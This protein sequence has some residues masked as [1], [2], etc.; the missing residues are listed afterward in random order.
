MSPK[1]IIVD[2]ERC[3]NCS[4]CVIACKDEFVGN[5]HAPWSAPQK[6]VGQFWIDVRALER[7]S[8]PRLKM[9]FLPVSCQHCESPACRTACPTGAI[10]Q[11]NDGLTWIDSTL[12]DGCGLCVKA[13]PYDAI[14][15]DEERGLAQKCTGCAHLVDEGALPRCVEACPHDVF[16]FVDATAPD[17]RSDPAIS[18]VEVLHPEFGTQPRV[19]WRNLPL[20]RLA[21]AVVERQEDEVVAGAR[22]TVSGQG[23]AEARQTTTDA[24]GQFALERLPPGIELDVLI[25]KA[26]YLPWTTRMTT[27]TDHDLGDVAL[28]RAG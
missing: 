21:G 14:F 11:R 4:L 10:K 26:G 13:C 16:D 1:T 24:F 5:D 18:T 17:L 23:L 25:E 8:A 12:C 20:P 15:L 9:S 28:D 7:G 22:V 6:E 3:S 27:D 2:P 19:L